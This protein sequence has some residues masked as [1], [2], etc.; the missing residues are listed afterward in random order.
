M[1][2]PT[3]FVRI[4]CV[5][6]AAPLATDATE[7]P[8]NDPEDS[9]LYAKSMRQALAEMAAPSQ[10]QAQGRSVLGPVIILEGT[11]WSYEPKPGSNGTGSGGKEAEAGIKGIR[12]PGPLGITT[13]LTCSFTCARSCAAPCGPTYDEG[14]PTC[15][16]YPTCH[17]PGPTCIYAT[18]DGGPTCTVNQPTCIGVSCNQ[19]GPTCYGTCKPLECPTTLNS[20]QVPRPGEIHVSFISS[21]YLRY[22]LQCST[23]LV[24]SP[25]T[26]VS[27]SLGTGGVMT[28]SHTNNAPHACYRV[29]VQVP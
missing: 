2:T 3:S 29:Q 16:L 23:N 25:W 13:E 10:G 11:R 26:D 12:G 5:L 6:G 17:V 27:S 22:T 8:H 28:L 7:P 1:K 20:I 19:P 15:R 18:C 14:G 4:L 21:P 24:S 9:P